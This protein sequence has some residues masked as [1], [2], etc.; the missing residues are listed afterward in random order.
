M[1]RLAGYLVSIVFTGA[2]LLA[3]GLWIAISAIEPDLP[4]F[5]GLTDYEPPVL[6]R[7]YAATGEPIAQFAKQSRIF[8]PIEDVPD[9]VKAA[10]ISAEDKSFYSHP[11]LDF[12]GLARAFWVDVANVGSGRRPIGASTIT[13]QVAKNLLLTSDRTV[14]RKVKEALL[15]LKIERVLSKDRILEIYLNEIFLGE[16]SYGIA[17]AAITYFDKSVSDLSIAE[18]AYLAALP[19]GPANYNPDT[20]AQAAI[21]RRNWV[22]DRMQENGYITAAEADTAKQQPLGVAAHNDT[23]LTVDAGYFVDEVRKVLTGDFGQKSLDETGLSVRTTLDPRLQAGATQSLRDELV[24]YDERRGYRGPVN[25]LDDVKDWSEKLDKLQPGFDVPGWFP[26]VVLSTDHQDAQIGVGGGL[27]ETHALKAPGMHWALGKK[28]VSQLL[29]VGDVVIVERQSNGSF[30]LRQVPKVQGALV[31]MNPKTGRIMAM[32]GGFSH[33]ISQFN[34][35][36]QAMRQPGSTFKPI[37]YAAALDSGYTPASVIVDEPVEFHLGD[38]VWSPRNDANEYEGPAILRFGIEHSRNVMAAKLADA[39]GMDTVTSY[40]QRLGVYDKNVKPLLSMSIGSNETSLLRM[41]AAYAV[42]DNGGMQVKPTLIDR[43]QDRHGRT[44]YRQ[45]SVTCNECA[46]SRWQGQDEPELQDGRERVLDPMTAYQVTSMMESVVSD[47]TASKRI[48]LGRPVAGKTGT[49]NDNHDAWFVGFT[50]E[51][52]TGVYIGFDEPE[53]LGRAASGSGVA[54][55][56]FNSF[57]KVA[58]AGQPIENFHMPEGMQVY[59]I[60]VHSGMAALPGAP[61]AVSEPF[62]PGTKPADVFSTV[63]E[64]ETSGATSAQVRNAL[65]SNAAGLY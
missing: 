13:Q 1:I 39:V 18:A 34:R 5:G 22:I 38:Q 30:E 43:V 59:N 41:V 23:G 27:N 45:Q 26:A 17:Q 6:S 57:M 11:G 64:T 44:I 29:N 40:A 48:S 28:S 36:V 49:T 20:H 19:K 46:A 33:S 65:Q 61:G 63:D 3:G 60:D 24:A 50:P 37:V 9:R 2:L 58:L 31:A 42:I 52:V 53:S 55:P 8:L 15:S 54:A 7:V 47:G 4:D 12:S 16:R 35:A 25:H 56:V 14:S 62:K 21:T 32:V 51:L 10:F